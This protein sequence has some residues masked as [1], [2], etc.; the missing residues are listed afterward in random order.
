MNNLNF[1]GACVTSE[2]RGVKLSQTISYQKQK[3][4]VARLHK[5]VMNQ[6]NDYLNKL[7]TDVV[8]NKVLFWLV[9][10]G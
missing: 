4:M 8:K 3:R 10:V 9:C 5:K 7:S 2:K 6:R 1:R